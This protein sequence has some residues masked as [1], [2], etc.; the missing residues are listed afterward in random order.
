MPEAFLTL[1]DWAW[2]AVFIQRN[3][4]EIGVCDF[5]RFYP[6]SS[7]RL[8]VHMQAH[9]TTPNVFETGIERDLV[10]DFNRP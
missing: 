3:K 5:L 10:P 6:K 7:G 9:G 4:D 2:F 8:N 1:S